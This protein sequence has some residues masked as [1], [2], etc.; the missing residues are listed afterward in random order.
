MSAGTNGRAR[1]IALRWVA[2]ATELAS[3]DGV[4]SSTEYCHAALPRAIGIICGYQ[5]DSS[6][7]RPVS[8]AFLASPKANIT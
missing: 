2:R 3:E 8:S 7:K 5:S 6:S 1:G 4:T